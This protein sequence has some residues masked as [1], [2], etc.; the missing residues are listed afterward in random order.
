MDKHI[1]ANYEALRNASSRMLSAARAEDLDELAAAES[2]C[3]EIIA[4]LRLLGDGA[5]MGAA[6]ARRKT[7][8][9]RQILAD[10]AQIREIT[11]PWLKTLGVL[12][13]DAAGQRRLQGAY[14]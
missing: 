4:C 5:A 3:V 14:G 1:L 8:I 10:D 13:S 2:E 7:E 11:T 12:I 6:A 9:L